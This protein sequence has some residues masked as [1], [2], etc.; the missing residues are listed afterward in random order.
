MKKLRIKLSGEH[1]PLAYAELQSVIE[2]KDW[3]LKDNWLE[4]YGKL[5]QAWQRL[6]FSKEAYTLTKLEPTQKTVR[7]ENF[8]Q[9]N[10]SMVR[11]QILE[12]LGH[13]K[14][15][16]DN[17][18]MIIAIFD[19]GAYL[20]VWK[21]SEDF[22]ARKSH[23]RPSPH[24]TS[25]HPKL[26]RAMINLSGAQRAILDPFCGAGG[27]LIEAGLMG[28]ECTGIDIDPIMIKRAQDNLSS[29]DIPAKLITQD[30]CEY[31]ESAE[32]IVSDLPYGRNSKIV[33]QVVEKFLHQA[34]QISNHMVIAVHEPLTQPLN[35]QIKNSFEWR[36]HKSL[37]KHVYVLHLS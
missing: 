34:Q 25:L 19:D 5:D 33:D 35:W 11:S 4:G 2:G 6:A 26:A 37:T 20:Q 22:Q 24:P 36:L 17:P 16:L 31:S 3:K 30:A 29:L 12:Q 9:K 27:I 28:L 7:I 23:K 32:T 15:N 10:T 8:S 21:N 14:V 1:I 18:E 13:P